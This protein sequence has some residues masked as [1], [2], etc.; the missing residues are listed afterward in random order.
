MRKRI[1]AAIGAEAMRKLVAEFGG[2]QLYIPRLN[3]LSDAEIAEMKAL[4]LC[5]VSVPE[6]ARRKG[7]SIRTVYR[8]L[9][10]G[11]S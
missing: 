4:H 7:V 9:R 10:S 8:A 5:D 11:E 6:L 3:H 2:E 1:E